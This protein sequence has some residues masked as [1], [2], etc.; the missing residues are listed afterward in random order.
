MQNAFPVN[1]NDGPGKLLKKSI[2]QAGNECSSLH[3]HNW[4]HGNTNFGACSQIV[5]FNLLN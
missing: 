2:N 4:C 1:M 5:S 3:Y